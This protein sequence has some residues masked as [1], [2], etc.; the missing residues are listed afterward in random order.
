MNDFW[1]FIIFI[2][3]IW[4]VTMLLM[5]LFLEESCAEIIIWYRM[6]L[7]TC[8]ICLFVKML[9]IKF[10]FLEALFAA[11]KAFPGQSDY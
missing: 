2:V 1:R 6:A 4:N 7:T 11:T 10:F 5:S 9:F 3:C 8:P